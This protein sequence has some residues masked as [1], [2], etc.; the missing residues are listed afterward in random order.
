VQSEPFR[1]RHS[2]GIE[3]QFVSMRNLQ[4]HSAG[5][6]ACGGSHERS[7]GMT[8]RRNFLRTSAPAGGGLVFWF[9]PGALPRATFAQPAAPSP[10]P[11][12]GG[13]GD[14]VSEQTGAAQR[15]S[16]RGFGGQNIPK[17]VDAWLKIGQDGA[18]SLFTGKVEFGQGIQTAFGQ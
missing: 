2:S 4:P 7:R 8:S 5:R 12:A 16:G 17:D 9:S 13:G 1:T 10:T 11:A 14:E 3:R 15:Q 18:I 6:A